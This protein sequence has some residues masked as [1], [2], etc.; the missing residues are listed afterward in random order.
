M[1]HEATSAFPKDIVLHLLLHEYE[2]LTSEHFFTQVM[3]YGK[4]LSDQLISMF[5]SASKKPN[6][7][8]PMKPSKH[9]VLRI[10]EDVGAV[11][12]VADV[13]AENFG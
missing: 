10:Y 1:I 8:F 7:I 4:T 13:L 6:V 11:G 5:V 12:G 2:D 3:I 9:I